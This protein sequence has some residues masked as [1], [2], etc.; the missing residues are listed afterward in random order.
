MPL[1][2]DEAGRKLGKSTILD[3]SQKGIWLDEKRTSPYTFY[4]YFRQLHDSQ[5][6]IF[7]RYFSLRPI[8]EIDEILIEHRKNLGKWV[9]QEHL[10]SELTQLV[11]GSGKLEGAKTCSNILFNGNFT[12]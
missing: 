7:F 10:A 5:A 11:H 1:L 9:A 6:E 3:G 8:N 2:E 12:L 4:Q